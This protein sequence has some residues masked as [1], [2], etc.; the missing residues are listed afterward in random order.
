MLI[1]IISILIPCWTAMY[2]VQAKL[3]KTT[4]HVYVMISGCILNPHI[5]HAIIFMVLCEQ[6]FQNVL[7]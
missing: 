3:V 4:E 5:H 7:C 2:S 1:T 6:C